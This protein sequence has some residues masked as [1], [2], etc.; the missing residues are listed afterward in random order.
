MKKIAVS[1]ILAT[2]CV[3]ACAFSACGQT[4]PSEEPTPVIE[5]NDPA[6]DDI[7]E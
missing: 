6:M 2:L 5:Y 4:Q 3:M 1:I 7:Y